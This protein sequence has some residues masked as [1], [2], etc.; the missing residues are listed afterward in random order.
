MAVFYLHFFL[1][2]HLRKLSLMAALFQNLQEKAQQ[3]INASPLAGHIPGTARASSPDGQPS[4]NQAA[5]TGG[6][7]NYTLESLQHQIRLFGQQY[8]YVEM[9]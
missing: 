7:R 9:F 5:A 3:A 4:A 2:N 1:H 6:S 8:S